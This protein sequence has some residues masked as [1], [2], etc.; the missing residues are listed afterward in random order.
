MFSSLFSGSSSVP[1]EGAEG[2]EGEEEDQGS[3]DRSAENAA[4]PACV[5]ILPLH[6]AKH[7]PTLTH[8]VSRRRL[9]GFGLSFL[10]SAV[11][12]V[13]KTVAER[14]REAVQS[15]QETDWKVRDSLLRRAMQALRD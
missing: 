7:D 6:V 2:E 15:V 1:V 3:S 13:T 8:C 5:S 12:A 9:S 14:A 4:V 10:S 11:T